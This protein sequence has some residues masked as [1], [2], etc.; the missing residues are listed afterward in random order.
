MAKMLEKITLVVFVLALV[1]VNVLF[2]NVSG[3]DKLSMQNAEKIA[4]AQISGE[5]TE[6]EFEDNAYEIDVTS[7]GVE[8]EVRVDPSTGSVL[9]V[10]N[11]EVDIPITGSALEKA[12]A[13]ALKHIGK[14]RVT[15]TEVGDE[16]GYYEV[17]ISLDNGKEVDVHLDENFNV[18]SEEW[19]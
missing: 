18:L 8:T 6:S 15:D 9:S 5:V 2:V 11:E 19:D 16:E 1:T 7:N 3:Q 10:E 17:E 14:G 4:L 13:A 12:S